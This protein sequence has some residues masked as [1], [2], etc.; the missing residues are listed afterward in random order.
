LPSV[1]HFAL[2]VVD[3]SQ[4]ATLGVL[5]DTRSELRSAADHGLE[6]FERYA[7]SALRVAK[8][9]VVR[10]DD[11]SKGVLVGAERMLADV[12]RAARETTQVAE[13]KARGDG[14]RS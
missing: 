13:A 3:R 9:I 12:V 14:A 7:A 1:V 8:S 4:V 2:D 6:L 10:V 11:T 5:N